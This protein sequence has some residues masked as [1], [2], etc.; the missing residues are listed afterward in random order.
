MPEEK[1]LIEFLFDREDNA[2]FNLNYAAAIKGFKPDEQE[3]VKF[4]ILDYLK[5]TPIRNYSMAYAVLDIASM[6]V[7]R[8]SML[9]VSSKAAKGH[10]R[11][12]HTDTTISRNDAE[13]INRFTN[14]IK[15]AKEQIG[16]DPKSIASKG[17]G[18][19]S[20]TFADVVARGTFDKKRFVCK[21]VW[22]MK[23]DE[24]AS[25]GVDEF[26][27]M[28]DSKLDIYLETAEVK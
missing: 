10:V 18:S 28:D 3:T 22:G 20:E 16:I 5:L 15:L 14:G 9:R 13:A 24:Q 7:Q 11:G 19:I 21:P 27:H 8:S 23:K 4:L 2:R 26:K 25:E 1:K 17:D 12:E 6:E